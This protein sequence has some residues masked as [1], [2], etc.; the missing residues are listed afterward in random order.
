MLRIRLTRTGKK[1][2]ASYRIV[3]AEHSRAVKGKYVEILGHYLPT[4]NPKEIVLKKDRIQYWISVGAKPTNSVAALCKKEGMPD[5]DKFITR[6]MD[7][8]QPKKNPTEEE[9]AQA[10]EASAE[11]EPAAAE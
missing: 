10:A 8:K 11:S 5:M 3:V 2:Q 4:R 6:R 7:L 1:N 9:A